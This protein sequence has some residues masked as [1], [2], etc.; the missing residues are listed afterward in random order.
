MTRE[1]PALTV[2]AVVSPSAAGVLA[3]TDLDRLGDR[4]SAGLAGLLNAL[5][6]PGRPVVRVRSGDRPARPGQPVRLVVGDVRCRYPDSLPARIA[7]ADSGV[8]DG[9]AT[10]PAESL[11]NLCVEAVRRQP[12]VLVGLPQAQAYAED[13]G[14]ERPDP[15]WLRQVLAG[16][17]D[18]RV[19]VSRR[20]LVAEIL[21]EAGPDPT[22]AR[23]ALVARLRPE[24]LDIQLAPDYLRELFTRDLVPVAGQG[25]FARLRDIMFEELGM[26]L[27]PFRLV[28]AAHLGPC[29]IAFKI[30]DLAGHPVLGLSPGTVLLSE[31]AGQVHALGFDATPA[32]N[33]ATSQEACVVA[34]D[35]SRAND[36]DGV[37]PLTYL[38][39]ELAAVL[40][41]HADCLID[42]TGTGRL[43]DLLEYLYPALRAAV[44]QS[45]A[46]VTSILRGLVA[47][48]VPISNLRRITGRLVDAGDEFLA[49]VPVAGRLPEFVRL[50]MRR[51]LARSNSWQPGTAAVYALDPQIETSLSASAG[52]DLDRAADAVLDLL[53]H[54][55]D[56]NW[57]QVLLTSPEV[58][59]RLARLLRAELPHLRV[60]SYDEVDPQFDAVVL[61]RLSLLS[62]AG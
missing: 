51:E 59:P 56:A 54:S 15:D 11:A 31:P 23:E 29:R 39:L 32:R 12:G 35:V 14:G 30:N 47:E 40:R 42:V 57:T 9:D 33:P 46:E 34:E 45:P 36:L 20:S 58:R 37:T 22:T 62:S 25:L 7:E 43:L 18:L 1:P 41:R 60:L 24:T 8:R 27:P 17:L 44:P 52:S 13:L 6:V 38:V 4:V 19:S 49:E 3:R 16:V 53:S 28:P 61:E 2:E 5:G 21:G 50:G 48:G 10:L 26:R 55:I